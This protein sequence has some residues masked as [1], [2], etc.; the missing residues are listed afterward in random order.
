M[1]VKKSR[2]TATAAEWR[3]QAEDSAQRA[4][5]LRA[6]AAR[7]NAE[8]DSLDVEIADLRGN[9]DRVDGLAV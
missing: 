7:L 1:M 6:Q 2:L 3:K 8:A 5:K 9:A 4:A